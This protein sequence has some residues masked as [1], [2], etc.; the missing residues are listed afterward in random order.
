MTK[1]ELIKELEPYPDDME[2]VVFDSYVAEECRPSPAW[3][4]NI[5]IAC[6]PAHK[7]EHGYYDI[8]PDGK[9]EVIEL[10]AR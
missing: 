9:E 7:A 1:A 8:H 2:V 5:S 6:L 10:S 4:S 3:S